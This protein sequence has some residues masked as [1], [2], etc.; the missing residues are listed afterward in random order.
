LTVV[1]D[2]DLVAAMA[3][4][5]PSGL[6][7][8][9]RRYAPRL[10]AYA[11]TL[12]GDGDSAADI[13]HDTI[14]L[15]SERVAQLRDPQRLRPWLYSIARHEGLRQLRRHSRH[16]PLELAPEPVAEVTDPLAAAQSAEIAELVRAAMAG[17]SPVDREIAELA[18]RHTLSTPDIAAVLGIAENNARARLSR[19]REQLIVALGVL[20]VARHSPCVT[21][22]TLLDGWDGTLNPPLRKR[23]HRHIED[24]AE[25]GE[26]R[27]RRLNPA[28]LLSGYAALPF[29][30][31]VASRSGRSRR[32]VP[33]RLVLVC[34]LALLLGAGVWLAAGASRGGAPTP[35]ATLLTSIEPAATVLPVQP[36]SATPFETPFATPSAQ[37]P[38]PP[39]QSPS[40]RP[41]AA[42]PPPPSPP[43]AP[44]LGF[45]ASATCR[46]VGAVI[47][48]TVEVTANA[49]LDTATVASSIGPMTLSVSG[50]TA[51]GS[52]TSTVSVSTIT[53]TA[54]VKDRTGRQRQNGNTTTTCV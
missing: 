40:R 2:A 47:T 54:T 52:R 46:R 24:C 22:R 11:R 34:S 16:T 26:A 28:A 4:K 35:A 39:A 38:A 36:P 17:M 18:L 15:A 10:F 30:P 8:I 6:D 13:V 45:E 48:F 29:A 49:A 51:Q 21:L 23:L 37:A 27:S 25:C 20:L 50:H 53:W 14:L 41:D 44:P 19:A 1:E 42:P 12:V 33:G 32:D 9:Y 31:F 43:P 5:D 3:R 7:A